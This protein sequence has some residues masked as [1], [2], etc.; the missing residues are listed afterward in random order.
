MKEMFQGK[1]RIDTMRDP[2]NE[3]E[4]DSDYC[5]LPPSLLMKTIESHFAS[6]TS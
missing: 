5:S 2:G 3:V 1:E 4:K 6:L